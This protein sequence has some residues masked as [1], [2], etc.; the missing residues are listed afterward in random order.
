MDKE[1]E[2]IGE[3]PN[4]QDITVLPADDP[5]KMRLGW[6]IYENTGPFMLPSD[7][8]SCYETDQADKF[9]G[10]H[11]SEV[12]KLKAHSW[13]VIRQ[14]EFLSGQ[15]W[16]NLA[17]NY[18]MALRPSAIRVI[19]H[20]GMMTADAYTWRVTVFLREDNRTIDRIEQ[21]CNVGSIG[22]NCGH[23]LQ[24]K[25]KQQQ[26]GEKIP[27]FNASCAIINTEALA[28]FELI[29]DTEKL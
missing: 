1:P 17:L 4:R 20:G 7:D 21:E 28:K 25:L 12:S 26:T 3:F 18:V 19:R 24:L 14:L 8:N 23:D 29:N 9:L 16:N 22:A 15:P 6:T 5:K 11:G 27:Q 13:S 2:Y 10:C